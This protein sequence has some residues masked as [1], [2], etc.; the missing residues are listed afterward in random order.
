MQQPMFPIF[1][2]TIG[3]T[4][5]LIG[6]SSFSWA[7][8]FSYLRARERNAHIVLQLSPD[9]VE[10]VGRERKLVLTET[11]KKTLAKFTKRPPSVLGVESLGEPDCSCHISS[12]LWT[13]TSEVTIWIE[14][15]SRDPD[16]SKHYY[17]VRKHPG[18][19]T[20]NASGEIFAAGKPVSWAEFK[21]AVLAMKE[22]EYIQLSL[23][24][25]EPKNFA[26]RVR[27][28]KETKNFYYR[29]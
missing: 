9:Q 22:G 3:L 1:F 25:T 19:F 17:E 18:Y 26:A 6:S 23:P 11:Q 15:L 29:L 2:K 16:G 13:A 12:A 14:R 20:A 4:L 8:G 7:D 27:R 21:A 5:A 10:T 28:L 24:P